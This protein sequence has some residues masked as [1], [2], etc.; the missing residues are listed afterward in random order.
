MQKKKK[1][2]EKEISKKVTTKT[3]EVF[4]K[5]VSRRTTERYKETSLGPSGQPNEL[6]TANSGVGE[7]RRIR[8]S[9]RRSN[10]KIPCGTEKLGAR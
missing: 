9:R 6:V 4:P 7:R 10:N 8:G 1:K 5:A 2:T 3:S